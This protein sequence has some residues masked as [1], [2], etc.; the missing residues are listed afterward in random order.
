VA[1]WDLQSCPPALKELCAPLH[2]G[3]MGAAEVKG[4]QC[5]TQEKFH[6]EGGFVVT[7]YLLAHLC[8]DEAV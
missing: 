2:C 8:R 1:G 4:S 3:C 7:N 6:M 5:H